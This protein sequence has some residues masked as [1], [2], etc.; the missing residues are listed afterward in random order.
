MTPVEKRLFQILVVDASPAAR[1]RLIGL[2]QN[3]QDLQVIGSA[4]NGA[5]AVRLVKRLQ[6]D[7]VTIDIHMP[8]MDGLE[9]TQQIMREAPTP[10]VIIDGSRTPDDKSLAFK[11][12]KAGALTIVNKPDWNDPETCAELVRTVR[13]MAGVPVVHHWGPKG[14]DR[15][16]TPVRLPVAT[17]RRLEYQLPANAPMGD[18]ADIQ[19]IGIASSTGG[20]SALA[21]V[22]GKL[23][24]DYPLPILL[25]Q[26][27]APGF[28]PGLAVWLSDY[29]QL[30]VKIAEN[31][32]RLLP[33][34][35]LLAPEDYHLEVDERGSARLSTASAHKGL[36]P[37][38]NYLFHSLAKVYGRRALGIVLTG[39]GDDGAEGALSL[40]RAG[41]L[42][43]AQDE[44][45]SV[46]FG[47]PYQ[48]VLRNAAHQ[49]LNLD[50][51]ASFLDQLK[52]NTGSQI[53][54]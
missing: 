7:L 15:M 29:T 47:M 24:V 50:Q 48:V 34:Q 52:C 45:S 53:L 36:R 35:I 37:S 31:G 12:L 54:A 13:L 5:E 11:A 23:P 4:S 9:A 20:P 43:I 51:I 18:I 42:V 27:I 40:Y 21:T 6:P 30:K 19:V 44:Q 32:N 3:C 2:F 39:M 14:K 10:I 22:L 46:V 49:V 28:T 17:P 1:E 8:E 26:H 33:G 38:A 16:S 25:V 41:G